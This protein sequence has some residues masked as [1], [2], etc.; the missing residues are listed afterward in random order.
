MILKTLASN[1]SSDGLEN[2]GWS[3]RNSAERVLMALKMH[4]AMSASAIGEAMGATGE[5]TRQQL[6][7]LAEEGLVAATSQANG[8]GRPTQSWALTAAAQARFP[9]THAT[10]IVQ[11]L[12]VVRSSL[13]EGG[14]GQDHRR[15]RSRHQN[16]L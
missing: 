8:V 5:A 15:P 4:G 3:P 10:L 12:E 7:R 6:A 9:G 2:I 11:L 14:S 1:M 13:G 16:R